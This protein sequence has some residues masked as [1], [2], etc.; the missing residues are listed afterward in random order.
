MKGLSKMKQDK[1]IVVI[2]GFGGMGLYH[3]MLIEKD[4]NLK[5][6]LFSLFE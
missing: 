4:Q 6:K 2:V 5:V 3:S 1:L